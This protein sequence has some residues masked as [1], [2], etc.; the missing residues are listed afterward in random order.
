MISWIKQNRIELVVLLIILAVAAILRFYKLSA[1]M[2]FLGDE[3]R[4][5]LVVKRIL[6]DHHLPLLGPTTSVGNIYLGP[7]YYYM[8]AVSMAIFW[9]NPIGAAGMIAAIGVATVFL[10]YFLA[11]Q[12][13]GILPAVV[14]SFLYAISPVNIIY[15]R[16]SWNPNPAPFFALLAM[17]GFYQAR[18]NHNFRWLI[19]TGGA[20][21]AALQMHYLAL[22]LIP[23][24]AI[25]WLIELKAFK[26]KKY[27]IQ[28]TALAILTFAILMSPWVLFDL[29][30]DFLNFRAITALFTQTNSA[31]RFDILINL[32]RL[33]DIFDHKL[34]ARY[35]VGGNN[36]AALLLTMMII[37]TV[38]L[39]RKS[40]AYLALGIW[41]LVGIVGLSFYKKDIY[42]HY[43]GF[44][45]PVPFL[46]LAGLLSFLK[47]RL[48]LAVATILLILL[49]VLNL[50]QLPLKNPPNYQLQKT[51]QI[52]KFVISQSKDQPFNFALIAKSNYDAAYQ[53]YL[54]RYQYAPKVLPIEMTDQLFVVCEDDVCN[55]IGHAKYE[56]AAF[57]WAKIDNASQILGVKVYKLIHNPSGK[58]S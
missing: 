54:W 19:L 52:A 56:I 48:R 33:W 7:L 16:S 44:L 13:F 53:Y 31:V 21:A 26:Q 55:P 8:M 32:S 3:G 12:W 5:A 28:G 18:K 1:Y 27:F 34:I 36:L 41:L 51:Q 40:W 22:I 10:V 43:L 30:H 47:G 58:P 29:R 42:D 25:F 57:G 38:G 23:V 46:L 17:V 37:L 39:F 35:M 15:S 45:N 4:D 6:I 50:Q 11:R 9:L 24:F 14:A 49:S 20:L 2:T